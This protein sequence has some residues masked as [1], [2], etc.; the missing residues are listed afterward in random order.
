MSHFSAGSTASATISATQPL[1]DVLPWGSPLDVDD[2]SSSSASSSSD[3]VIGHHRCRAHTLLVTDAVS[4]D[5]RFVL[6]SLA[7][8]FLSCRSTTRTGNLEG[9][10]LWVSCGPL[11]ERQIRGASRKAAAVHIGGGGGGNDGERSSQRDDQAGALRVVSVPLELADAALRDDGF[12]HERYL[13]GLHRRIV[14]WLHHREFLSAET[15]ASSLDAANDVRVASVSPNRGPNLVVVDNLAVFSSLFGD[16]LAHKFLTAV[17]A[18]L[19]RHAATI[20]RNYDDGNDNNSDSND[21][22]N[23]NRNTT[24]TTSINLL[25]VRCTSP[26]DGGLYRLDDDDDDDADANMSKGERLRSEHARLLRPWLGMGSGADGG[27]SIPTICHS[28]ERSHH[29][30]LFPAG[31]NGHST[32][33]ALL[34]KCG[35]YECADGIVDVSPLESGYARDVSGRISFS[36][37]WGGRG[38]WGTGTAEGDVG[39]ATTTTKRGEDGCRSGGAYAS[40]CVNYR[41]ED[42]GVRVLRLRSR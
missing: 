3:D 41:C 29:R 21:N 30:S 13:K 11:S 32:S 17:R 20:S 40:M 10:V 18:S 23:D 31:G 27:G 16:V 34:H 6:H 36:S 5:A 1:S 22:D 19:K 8:Q 38:W 37:V 33:T 25:A 2:A 9:S 7:Q 26:D 24:V 12:S 39:G 28:E 4:T 15:A 35:M 14:H 42:G